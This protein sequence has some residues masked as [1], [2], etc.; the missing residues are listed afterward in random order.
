MMIEAGNSWRRGAR[1][2]H[3]GDYC[4]RRCHPAHPQIAARQEDRSGAARWHPHASG[5]V[6]Q[7]ARLSCFRDL[8]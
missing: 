8:S 3:Q 6:E 2:A 1:H 7:A 4:G 5:T